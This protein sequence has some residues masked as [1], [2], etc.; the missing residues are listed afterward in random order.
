MCSSQKANAMVYLSEVYLQDKV[1][2]IKIYFCKGAAKEAILR[3]FFIG[4]EAEIFNMA[5][6]CSH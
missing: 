3:N 1:L 4:E 5:Y 2:E 6:N